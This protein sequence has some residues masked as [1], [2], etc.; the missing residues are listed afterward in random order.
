[1]EPETKPACLPTE[2]SLDLL[3]DHA[4]PVVAQ[5]AGALMAGGR[6]STV[7]FAIETAR[8]IV[9]AAKVEP[10]TREYAINGKPCDIGV[11]AAKLA[12]S[13]CERI[14]QMGVGTYL[15]LA[16]DVLLGRTK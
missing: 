1:M 8:D 2:K 9:T 5:I 15:E 16:A 14:R 4:W 7:K 11:L 6:F 13:D 12:P 3:M 10:P